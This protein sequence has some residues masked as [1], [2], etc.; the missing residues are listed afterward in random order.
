MFD[1][2]GCRKGTQQKQADHCQ[3]GEWRDGNQGEQPSAAF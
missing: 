1:A 2:G 3:L